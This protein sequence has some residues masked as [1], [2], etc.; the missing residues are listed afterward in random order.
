[1]AEGS[2]DRRAFFNQPHV[3]YFSME[4]ALAN[5]I[6]TY[7]GG[8]GILAG[9][10][11]RTAADMALPLVAV[12]LVSRRGYFRQELSPEGEQIEHPDPWAPEERLR[13]LRAMVAVPMNGRDVWVQAWLYIHESRLLGRVPVILLDTDCGSNSP[14]D[15]RLTHH[16]YGGDEAY[17]FKQEVVLGI[18]GMR[19]LQALGVEVFQYHMN[20]GHSA[21]LAWALLRRY[22]YPPEDV[23]PGE[24]AYDF[25]RVR[26]LCTFTTHTPVEA[27]QDKFPYSLV[28]EC[29]GDMAD[30]PVLR[31]LAGE[32]A[33]NMTR[34]A[35]NLSEYVNGVAKRHAEVSAQLFPGYQVRAITNGVHPDTWASAPFHRLYDRHLVGWAVEPE[36]LRRA[37]YLPDAEVRTAHREAKEALIETVRERTGTAL[38]PE[39]PILGFARRMT[40]YKR[41]DLLFKDL[42]RLRAIAAQWPF[43]LVMAGKAHPQDEPGKRLIRRIHD[44][45]GVLSD[46]LPMAFLPDYDMEC[47]LALV[48]G[49]D[50]WLNTPLRPLEASGTSGMKA[51]FNGVP[52]LSVLDGWWVE[53]W[54]EGVTGW[55]VGD[56]AESANGT[57]AESLYHKL[58]AEVLPCYYDSPERW[59][60]IMKS[61][62]ALNASFFNTHRMMRRY[63]TEA[64]LS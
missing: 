4:I 57:D 6:P 25:H 60:G 22:A 9:D 51:A 40:A 41:P 42:D 28:T 37:A 43:Q 53:G 59:T 50:I 3:A 16:L 26:S 54:I 7:S 19:L 46:V 2:A 8:L 10:T 44:H 20:E 33:L 35:L 56:S 48:S 34:L 52:S 18:G 64:Y 1:M 47:A 5:G 61:T 11:I 13:K 45:M 49:V 31:S 38:D 39:K 63:A 12:T 55:A 30:L 21:L 27:G 29:L 23:R 24:S 14:E 36:L 17:R 15:R 58:S 62:I 32:E